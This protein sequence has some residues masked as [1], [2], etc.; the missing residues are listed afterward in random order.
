MWSP[1]SMP[2]RL[3][4]AGEIRGKLLSKIKGRESAVVPRG[5]TQVFIEINGLGKSGDVN[6][7]IS[8]HCFLN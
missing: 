5:G 6:R 2:I 7:R 8:L 3:R 4:A 1:I